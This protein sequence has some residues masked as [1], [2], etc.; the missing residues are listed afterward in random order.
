MARAQGFKLDCTAEA[1]ESL[2]AHMGAVHSMVTDAADDYRAKMRRYVYQTPKSYLSF[3]AFFRSLYAAKLGEIAV[4]DE[5]VGL[6]LQKLEQGGKVGGGGA[7]YADS[8]A[9]CCRRGCSLGRLLRVSDAYREGNCCVVV[10][11]VLY[12]VNMLTPSRAQD[13]ERMKV[14]LAAEEHKLFTADEA[15]T[16]M[17]GQLE[18]SSLEAKQEADAVGRIRDAC[19]ADALMCAARRGGGGRVRARGHDA[20]TA[21][22]TS[23]TPQRRTCPRRSRSWMRRTRPWTPSARPTS[24]S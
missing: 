15:C 6:G 4:M 8:C 21:S 16:K 12:D 1:R 3:V 18:M 13:V 10:I 14:S 24:L 17:L 9:S 20:R 5:R 19:E 7:L 23:A 22:E 2:V 11:C